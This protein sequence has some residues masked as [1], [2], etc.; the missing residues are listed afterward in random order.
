MIEPN[1][2][3]LG[4]GSGGAYATAAA[5]ALIQHTDQ[6]PEQVVRAAMQIAGDLCIYT[7]T[8]ITVLTL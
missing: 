6:N 2:N 7:N 3:I 8:N 1:D 4:I 5:R